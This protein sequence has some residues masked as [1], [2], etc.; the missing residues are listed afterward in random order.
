MEIPDRPFWH[1]IPVSIRAIAVCLVICVY[2][3]TNQIKS[4]SKTL[5]APQ[6]QLAMVPNT[7]PNWAS[8][9]FSGSTQTLTASAPR[10]VT[11]ALS[12]VSSSPA[13][14]TFG[15]PLPPNSNSLPQLSAT[16]GELSIPP[17]TPSIPAA[18]SGIGQ[19]SVTLSSDKAAQKAAEEAEKAS[20]K[21]AEEEAEAQR[22]AEAIARKAEEEAAL[23]VKK[24]AEAEAE[25]QRHA[26][27][28]ARK[29]EEEAA[30]AERKAQ[31]DL[32]WQQSKDA[33]WARKDEENA[34]KE[35]EKEEHRAE[36]ERL[37]LEK[38]QAKAAASS[39][40]SP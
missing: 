27:A 35:Q 17:I 38:Q 12:S 3:V 40:V 22:H 29:A 24:A 9:L 16:V 25:A 15:T 10:S 2:F 4:E 28:M 21:A 37:Q 5:R 19:P 23:A 20:K 36:E 39:V 1:T 14:S 33:K 13:L 7:P 31:K 6:M 26:E 34:A 18:I 8:N 11:P 30:E 32:E